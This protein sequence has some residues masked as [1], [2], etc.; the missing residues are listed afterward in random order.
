MKNEKHYWVTPPEMLVALD[1]EFHFDFDPCPH[2]RPD[3]FDGLVVPW[4]KRNW[5]NPPFTGPNWADWTRKAS[6]ERE[7]GKISV[8]IVPVMQSRAIR[9][10]EL[11]GAE[12]RYG[13]SPRWLPLED[14]SPNPAKAEDL[15]PCVLAILRPVREHEPK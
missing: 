6:A 13:G 1:A 4:G 14:A 7:N 5:V 12:M 8:F 10:F 3:G 9:R 15:C 11:L 2:P